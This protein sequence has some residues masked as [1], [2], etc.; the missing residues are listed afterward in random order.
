[1]MREAAARGHALFA[2]E[3]KDLMWQRGGKVGDACREITLTGEPARLVPTPQGR[4]AADRRW[5]ISTPS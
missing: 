4:R 2:C 1:M 5:P 3:P